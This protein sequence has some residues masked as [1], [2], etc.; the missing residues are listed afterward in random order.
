[1]V[2]ENNKRLKSIFMLLL[3]LATLTPLPLYSG[4]VTSQ[5]DVTVIQV[6]QEDKVESMR[7]VLVFVNAVGNVVLDISFNIVVKL[8]KS[9]PGILLPTPLA[10]S[11]SIP[12]MPLPAS[13]GYSVAIIPGLPAYNFI[14]DVPLVGKATLTISSSVKYTIMLNGSTMYIGDY[15]VQPIEY[16]KDLPPVV[17]TTVYDVL[18]N[19][20]L[21]N[22]T[23][24]LAPAGWVVGANKE[25]VVIAAAIDDKDVP[26]L[27]LEYSVSG[28]AWQ[29]IPLE[30][31]LPQLDNVRNQVNEW[32]DTVEKA[33]KSIKNDF[34]L[35]R[36]GNSFR[37]GLGV[38]PG[39][40][41]GEYIRFRARAK[42]SADQISMSLTGL[43]YTV[44]TNSPT[45]ILVIDPSVPLWL[46]KNNSIELAMY[47]ENQVAYGVPAEV[48][49]TTGNY[50][51]VQRTLEQQGP[52]FFHYWNNLG[53]DYNV[54]IVYP[55]KGVRSSLESFKPHIIILSNLYLG[56]SNF[57]VLNWD[58]K[59]FDVLDDIVKYVKQN[60]AGV[61]V[62][63]GTLS[64]WVIWSADCSSKVKVGSRGH[65]GEYLSDLNSVE[66]KTIAALLGLSELALWEYIRD[67]LATL[68]CSGALLA[69]GIPREAGAVV[70]SIPLLI[71]YIPFSGVL[72]A[73]P[74][75]Q[76]VDWFLPS[77][78]TITVPEAGTLFGF[79]AYTTIGWQLAQPRAVAYLA[80]NSLSGVREKASVAMNRYALLVENA[81]SRFA[82]RD[83]L[84]NYIDS[85]MNKWVRELYRAIVSSS[86]RGGDFSINVSLPEGVVDLNIS[87]PREVLDSLLQK[88]PVKVIAVSSDG[89]AGIV[90]Y[91]K[92]WDQNGYR[93]VY[94]SFEIE[95]S[96][97]PVARELLKQA[98]EWALK[99]E[100]KPV[101]ELLGAVRVPRDIAENFKSIID[102]L[103]GNATLTQSILLNEEGVSWIEIPA[104]PGRTHIVIAHPTTDK[105][106][107]VQVVGECNVTLITSVNKVTVITIDVFSRGAIKVGL[108]ASSDASLNPAYIQV[109]QEQ[110]P[111]TPTTTLSP[112]PTPTETLP[113]SPT[114]TS[115]PTFPPPTATPSPTPTLSPTEVL[116]LPSTP[117]PTPTQSTTLTP[118]L[119]APPTQRPALDYTMLL[120]GVGVVVAIVIALVLARKKLSP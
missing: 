94:F 29:S 108:K 61:I 68:I 14:F 24:G 55:G 103:P 116:P 54:Y 78:F 46:L 82:S 74:E 20:G 111:T 90:V 93:S 3:L 28:G 102:K 80:W 48:L 11:F 70:G 83:K 60:H 104:T 19:P 35:P 92:F 13:G 79:N 81:T 85:A 40:E 63:H 52:P 117:V 42:D 73:T 34:S 25:V 30:N 75:A 72:K 23:L 4:V 59:D 51:L 77:E 58:L 8:D 1:M 44:N 76:Y 120:A 99:W 67:S 57:T 106:D 53:R 71:P 15:T 6:P 38:I 115:T 39:Q 109:K 114:S 69:L 95:A 50:S 41:A 2:V 107:V 88:L 43:Y 17:F 101:T 33:V 97:D 36:L 12:M 91:D 66:E 84:F 113:P 89:L 86:I 5:Q 96:P 112:T 87:L 32:L 22:E 105:V 65:V 100:Y 21:F 119:T 45:R 9:L 7:P 62:T 98:V 64:D 10:Q 18:V 118:A 37:A 27:K 56:L 26:E 49:K 16:A 31:M 47:I 110:P